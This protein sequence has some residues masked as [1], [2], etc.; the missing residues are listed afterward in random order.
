M[1]LLVDIGN[2]RLKWAT[3]LGG[4][5]R[6]GGS[7]D[8]RSSSFAEQLREAWD[9][10]SPP[11]QLAIASVAAGPILREVLSLADALWPDIKPLLLRSSAYAHGVTNA[12]AQ[13]EKLGI[14]RW[15]A[16]IA[17]HH[18]YAGDICVVDCGTAITLDVVSGAGQHLGGLIAP[19]LTLMPRSLIQDTAL[20]HDDQHPAGAELGVFTSQAI[21][22]GA[23][24]A[25]VGLVESSMSRWASQG[26]L[27][28]T[29]G[30]ALVVAEALS[31]KA[32]LDVLLVFKGLVLLC[33]E[34]S[35]P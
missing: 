2:S 34:Y 23:L 14:D 31:V 5:L 10:A 7:L 20:L 11:R 18:E 8:Y 27:I 3:E 35:H 24:M 4:T 25:A 6:Q 26:R 28:L 12:Y 9:F 19:G 16:I 21:V 13:P 30:D 29:G 15:L 17:A 33:S 1:K 32:T 22:N